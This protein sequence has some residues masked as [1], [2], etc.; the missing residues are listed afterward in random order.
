MADDLRARVAGRH[1]PR[2]EHVA[3]RGRRLVGHVVGE[4]PR[5]EVRV[6]P[7][8]ADTRVVL[9]QLRPVPSRTAEAVRGH[10]CLQREAEYG[11]VQ[12]VLP[13]MDAVTLEVGRPALLFLARTG[14]LA[15]RRVTP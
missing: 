9:G 7:A 1:V 14:Q 4:D 12:G 11:M 5:D 15:L 2:P 3:W 13:V 10:G 8:A 6:G